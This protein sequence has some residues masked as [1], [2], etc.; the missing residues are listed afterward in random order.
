MSAEVLEMQTN[1]SNRVIT[2]VI[3]EEQIVIEAEQLVAAMLEPCKCKMSYRRS[4]I[5]PGSNDGMWVTCKSCALKDYWRC[6]CALMEE[7]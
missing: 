7:K 5:Y 6:I 4:G 1:L 3:L 2:E